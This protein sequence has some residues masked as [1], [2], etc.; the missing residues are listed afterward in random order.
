MLA[1]SDSRP[2]APDRTPT[3]ASL[4][5]ADSKHAS[6]DLELAKPPAGPDYDDP[7][8]WTAAPSP[9]KWYGKAWAWLIA[10]DSVEDHGVG[11]LPEHAR[12]D[13]HFISN[14]TIWLT[15]N[16]TIS[17][18]STGTLGPLFYGLS[19]RDSTLVIVF[20]NLF[21]CGVPAYVATFGPRMGMR[22]MG[23]ARF[24]YYFAILPA[25][26]NVISFIGFCAVNSIVAGQVLAAVNP[27]HLS[28]NAGIVIVAVISM[29]VS[30]CGYKVL[31]TMER[32]AWMPV[33]LAFIL[34]AG[35]GA[36]HLGSAPSFAASEPA[37]A[38]AV[39]SFIS[40]IVGFT[41]SWSGC[42]ADFNT[43]MRPDI[44]SVRVCLYTFAGLYLPCM[45]VQ[46]MG[47]AFAAA[48]LSG[49]V[50]TWE[51]A[52]G[53]GSV[54]GLVGVAVEPM[55]GFGKFLLVLFSLGMISNN[56][57]TQYAFSLSLQIVFPF[58][59]RLPRFLLPIVGTA[60]YLPIAIAAAAHFAS[61]L[62]NFLGLLG[63]W[64]SIFVAILL[65]E[66]LLFRKGRFSAYDL[67]FWNRSSRLPPGL[68]AL[69]ASLCGAALVVVGMDQ[70][71]FRGPLAKLVT[72]PDA[73]AGGD[74]AFETGMAV[75]AAVYIPARWLE[76]R[77]FGR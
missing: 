10:S 40:I 5:D 55:R 68:A 42:S 35:F 63:Y 71:W 52:F 2:P 30:F 15:M 3:A 59:T 1:S 74:I 14:F 33:L 31:H 70:V 9:R 54:G 45:L 6:L 43:Y 66:H 37:T 28:V 16:M 25:L 7:T 53:D 62:S 73:H 50:P 34:L 19:L 27:G 11:P 4:L 44:S 72:G 64:S 51:A 76:R 48:A 69:F 67:T 17:C 13:A 60:I 47:A 22:T 61:A 20:C 77:S 46:V 57:P 21:S 26:L 29:L 49:A 32:W 39:F 18:F 41:I 75:A 65:V 38:G 58:L 12:T 56:A 24:G 8:D 36:R 23:I